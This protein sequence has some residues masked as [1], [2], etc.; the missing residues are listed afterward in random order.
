MI[1]HPGISVELSLYPWCKGKRQIGL[2]TELGYSYHPRSHHAPFISLA[3]RYRRY[4]QIHVVFLAS[5]GV[6][7]MHSFLDGPVYEIKEGAVC[8]KSHY[9]YPECMPQVGFGLGYPVSVKDIHTVVPQIH[10]VVF[11]RYPY[12]SYLLPSAALKAGLEYGI[13]N[14]IH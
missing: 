14:P 4:T 10:C 12:N 9:G 3:L 6:G 2:C 7:Y 1:T 11:G 13:P 5:A 8:R